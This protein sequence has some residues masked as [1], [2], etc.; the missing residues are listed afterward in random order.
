MPY[1][2]REGGSFHPVAISLVK[3]NLVQ[4]CYRC[5]HLSFRPLLLLRD[6]LSVNNSTFAS[7]YVNPF[8]VLEHSLRFPRRQLLSR[9]KT[10]VKP[11][12]PLNIYYSNTQSSSQIFAGLLLILPLLLK[13]SAYLKCA[14]TKHIRLLVQGKTIYLFLKASFRDCSRIQGSAL[15]CCQDL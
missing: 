1:T 9:E 13:Y 4:S 11:V 15:S 14:P 12:S 7:T 2:T 8:T 10:L 3:K 5:L 6:E